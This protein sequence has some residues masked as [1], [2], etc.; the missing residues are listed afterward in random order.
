MQAIEAHCP[1]FQPQLCPFTIDK[2]TVTVAG[3][4]QTNALYKELARANQTVAGRTSMTVSAGGYLTGG[5][6][7]SLHPLNQVLDKE[8]ITP[9]GDIV[10]ANECQNHD[11][12]WAMRSVSH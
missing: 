8:V 12:F 7:W 9:L 4:T 10:V 5:G 6:H 11:L 2:R 1:L 3:G